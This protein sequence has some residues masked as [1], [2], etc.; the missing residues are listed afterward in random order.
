M[1]TATMSRALARAFEAL[2][3][4]HG[5]Y[6][7]LGPIYVTSHHHAN[8]NG[9]NAFE[10]GRDHER[11]LKHRELSTVATMLSAIQDSMTMGRIR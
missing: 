2:V 10:I 11:S 9:R 6:L 4:R 5:G 3:D 8:E 7:S 1:T